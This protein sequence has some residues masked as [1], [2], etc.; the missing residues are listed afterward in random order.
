MDY[1]VLE[2][3]SAAQGPPPPS[4]TLPDGTAIDAGR[5]WEHT[6][7]HLMQPPGAAAA[8][9]ATAAQSAA[10]RDQAEPDPSTDIT[11]LYQIYSDDVLG[12]GQFG[13]V[14]RGVHRT[15]GRQVAI[16]MINKLRFPNKQET[17]L[18]NEVSIL[19][20]VSHQGVVSGAGGCGR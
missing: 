8:P 2:R 12:S 14:Y 6:I 7:R 17:Q 20:T 19:Q 10:E 4:I 3:P 18:K 15:S 5:D 1:F 11:T 13:I 9:P 16:K